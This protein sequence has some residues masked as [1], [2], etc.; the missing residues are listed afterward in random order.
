LS[1]RQAQIQIADLQTIITGINPAALVQPGTAP[2]TN[3]VP[4]LTSTI[5]VGPT[6]DVIPNVSAD[7]Q[8]IN[9]AVIPTVTEFLGYDQPGE[10]GK[11]RVWQDGTEK[12][13]AQP[14]PRF[15]VRQMVTNAQVPDGQTLVLGGLI[16][17]ETRLTKDKVPVLGDL[18]AMG[19]LFRNESKQAVK[20]NLLVFITATIVDPAGNPLKK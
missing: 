5:P 19:N 1:G 2:G 13:V 4:F 14:L 18:P 15:R 16:V 17:E 9:L 3:T 12:S 6:L 10:G 20:K 7:N 8:T 11:V